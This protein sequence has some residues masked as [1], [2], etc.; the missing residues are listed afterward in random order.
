MRIITIFSGACCRKNSVVRDILN[1]TDCRLITDD[2][3]IAQ[4]CKLSGIAEEKI[5]RAFTAKT[6][7][8]N[9]FTREKEI[10]IAYLKLALGEMLTGDHFLISG[11]SGILIP[12]TVSHV[13]KVC[14]I[15]DMNS[16]IARAV[17]TQD[18]AKK[19]AAKRIRSRDEDCAAWIDLLYSQKDPWVP[20]LYDLVIPTDQTGVAKAGALI[21]EN[22]LKDVVTPTDRSMGAL[23]DFRL[24]ARVEVALTL[25]GH[26][27]GVTARGE[28]V[29]LTI[30]KHV[31]MLSRLEEELASIATKVTGVGSVETRVGEAYHRSDV[32]RK[33]DFELPSKVLLVDDER[34]FVQTLSERLEL[35]DM[36]SAVAFDGESALTLVRD[37][38]P[39]VMIIDLKMPGIS[40]IE[41]LQQVKAFRPEIEVIVL[42]GHGADAEMEECMALGAFGYLQKPVDIDQLS[43]MLKKAHEKV[44]TGRGTVE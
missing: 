35:R 22:L 10:S 41:V 42:T 24:A 36:G 38:A 15:A 34:E 9:R 16:R 37:D 6:S 2:E 32:Y 19:E 40:G 31:L 1:S 3:V 11:F 13:L 12:Q 5:G 44:R 29:T 28:A 14:L 33:H 21:A 8:F 43:D 25:E 26:N 20:L 18:L 30:N 27:V 7:V 23:D 39:D 4:A 17:E